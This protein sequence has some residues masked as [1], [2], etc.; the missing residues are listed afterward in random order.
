MPYFLYRI[1]LTPFYLRFF[2]M[3]FVK[4]DQCFSRSSKHKP[5]LERDSLQPLVLREILKIEN[6]FIP[7]HTFGEWTS[8]FGGVLS[9]RLAILIHPSALMGYPQGIYMDLMLRVADKVSLHEVPE[10][11]EA[12]WVRLG[13]VFAQFVRSRVIFVIRWH[14]KICDVQDFAFYLDLLPLCFGSCRGLPDWLRSGEPPDYW[15]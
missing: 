2:V 14:G 10:A 3:W 7:L 12:L 5:S 8:S 4:R 15:I 9:L 6:L 1:F 13:P 11:L